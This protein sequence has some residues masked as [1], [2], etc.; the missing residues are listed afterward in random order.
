MKNVAIVGSRKY[1]D[2]DEVKAYVNRLPD[3]SVIVSG[4]AEGVDTA[5]VEAAEARGLVSLVF[6]P[7]WPRFGKKA[8]YIRNDEIVRA[9]DQVVAFWDGKSKGTANSIELAKEQHKPL[10]IFHPIES[11]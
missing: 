8:A 2:L 9:A 3:D 1:P 11:I 7:D 5:A 4:G 10:M 6:L